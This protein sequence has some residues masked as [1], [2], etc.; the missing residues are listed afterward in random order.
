MY[1]GI[2]I[3]LARCPSASTWPFERIGRE[4]E[5]PIPAVVGMQEALKC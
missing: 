3:A 5:E 1:E 2:A 4:R